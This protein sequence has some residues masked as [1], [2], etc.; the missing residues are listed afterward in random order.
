MK[1][2]YVNWGVND[3]MEVD[4]RSY[5]RSYRRNFRTLYKP[6]IF[7]G[8]LFA[9]AKVTVYNCDL[10]SY[11]KYPVSKPELKKV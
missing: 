7:S 5:H 9:S 1:V 2:T 11:K 3:Y 8:F 10:L 4:Y 6:E